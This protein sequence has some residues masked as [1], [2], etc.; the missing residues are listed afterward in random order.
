MN[1]QRQ[2]K[3]PA[4]M[5]SGNNSAHD[6]KFK[7]LRALCFL[8]ISKLKKIK[9]FFLILALGLRYSHFLIFCQPREQGAV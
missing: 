1:R 4:N 8:K 9:C 3:I 6:Q 2:R 5:E 7:K